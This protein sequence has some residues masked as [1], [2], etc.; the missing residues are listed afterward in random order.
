MFSLFTRTFVSPAE[1]EHTHTH[2]HTH[3]L[4]LVHQCRL[5]PLWVICMDRAIRN[6]KVESTG[7]TCLPLTSF[8]QHHLYILRSKTVSFPTVFSSGPFLGA[9]HCTS[10]GARCSSPRSS[11]KAALPLESPRLPTSATVARSSSV[12]GLLC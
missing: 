11:A 6:S 2:T 5:A 10:C 1:L 7:R 8:F 9:I 12:Q 3:V 4:C